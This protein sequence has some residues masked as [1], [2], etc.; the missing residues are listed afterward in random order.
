MNMNLYKITNDIDT[1]WVVAK[2]PTEAEETLMKQLQAWDYGFFNH[3][4]VR[5]I[6]FI[7]EMEKY[8]RLIIGE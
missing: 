2:H 3:R 7:A 4:K 8:G 1:W 5:T 6:E